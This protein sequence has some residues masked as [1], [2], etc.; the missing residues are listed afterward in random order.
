MVSFETP[1]AVPVMPPVTSPAQDETLHSV[2]LPF[3]W[4]QFLTSF[5]VLIWA[6]SKSSNQRFGHSPVPAVH[7][8]GSRASGSTCPARM[9]PSG[10]EPQ[11][12]LS[13]GTLC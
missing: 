2:F 4:E 8:V 12:A 1:S 5:A 11:R 7:G 9:A 10:A 3:K 13:G 6:V